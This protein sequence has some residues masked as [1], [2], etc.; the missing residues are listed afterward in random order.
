MGFRDPICRLAVGLFL[1]LPSAWAQ[2]SP[3]NLTL[4]YQLFEFASAPPYPQSGPATAPPADLT[5]GH[6]FSNR[7]AFIFQEQTNITLTSDVAINLSQPGTY[8]SNPSSN[9]PPI[10]TGMPNI[11]SFLIHAEPKSSPNTTLYSYVGTVVFPPN[12][13]ILGIIYGSMALVR[14][15]RNLG[16]ITTRYSQA[17][18]RGFNLAGQG[19]IIVISNDRHRVLF[20]TA[21]SY[22]DEMRIVVQGSPTAAL[23]KPAVIWLAGPGR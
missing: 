9:P 4:G 11:T 7:V 12:V 6:V 2:G 23:H 19:E 8:T 3:I 1:L 13:T 22:M 10:P 21:T 16:M 5:L 18:Y 20:G 17:T 14:T 15:D